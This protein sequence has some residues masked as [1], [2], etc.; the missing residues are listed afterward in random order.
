MPLGSEKK[1]KANNAPETV[2]AEEIYKPTNGAISPSSTSTGF[3]FKFACPNASQEP[4]KQEVIIM[5]DWDFYTFIL[6]ILS[7]GTDSC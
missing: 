1:K 2:G 6:V 7:G 4:L 5:D 3:S